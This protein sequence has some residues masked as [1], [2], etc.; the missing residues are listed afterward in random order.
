M[1]FNGFTKRAR[2]ARQAERALRL[3]REA[4][5]CLA[6]AVGGKDQSAAAMLID[7]ALRLAGRSRELAHD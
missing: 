1:Q 2:A 7:E 5:N 6:V 3:R 4:S